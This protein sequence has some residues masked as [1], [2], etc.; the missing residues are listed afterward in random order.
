[1]LAA[2]QLRLLVGACV[3]TCVIADNG[4]DFSNNLFTDLAPLLA[5]FGERVTMQF[6]SQS[7]G[8]A[9]N[10]ILAMAPLGIMTAMVGA[11]RVGGPSWLKAI[12]GRAR[13]SRAVAEAEL[14]SSTSNDVCELWNGQEIVRV[15]GSGPIREFVILLPKGRSKDGNLA[16][17]RGLLGCLT[18]RYPNDGTPSS[19]ERCLEMRAMGLKDSEV[20]GYIEKYELVKN[21]PLAVVRN[22]NAAI[23]NLTLNVHNQVGRGELY[24]VAVLGV[25]LQLG[26]L[27]YCGFATRYLMLPKDG[28]PVDDYA[29]PCTACGTLLLI[30][31]MLLCAHI[32]ETSTLETRYRPGP[33]KEARVIWLQRSGTVNDQAFES[34]AIFPEDRQALVTTSHRASGEQE[35]S[36]GTNIQETITVAGVLIS[37]SGFI[38]Q[39]TGLH[40]MHWSASVAQLGAIIVMTILRAPKAFP[41]ISGHELDWLAMTL[42]KPARAPW[43]LSPKTCTGWKK[44][45]RPWID[46]DDDWDWKVAV[47]EDPKGREILKTNS[48]IDSRSKAHK[49]MKIRRDLSEL[50]DWLGPASIEAISLARAIEIV[51]DA[52]FNT[53]TREF[54]WSLTVSGKQLYFV[55]NKEQERGREKDRDQY[56]AVTTDDTWLQAKGTLVK[57]NLQLLDTHTA[58]LYRDLR[59][60]MPDGPVRVIEVKVNDREPRT[61]GSVLQIEDDRVV[62]FT[63]GPTSSSSNDSIHQYR[64]KP[65]GPP[66]PDSSLAVESFSPLATLYTQY[67]FSAFMWAAA[68]KMEKPLE[69]SAD[70]RRSW[71]NTTSADPALQ[72]IALQSTQLSKMAQD[73]QTTGIGSLEEIYLAIIPPLSAMDRLPRPDPV[74]KWAR[75]QA[76]SHEQLGHWKEAADVYMQLFRTAETFPVEADI[77][78]MATALLVEYLRAV[79]D[80][81]ELGKAQLFDERHVQ[82]LEQ[83]KSDLDTKLQ[84]DCDSGILAELMGLHEAQGRSWRCSFVKE[85]E[86]VKDENTKLKFTTLHKAACYGAMGIEQII[87]ST[88]VNERDIF[89]W[90]PLHYAATEPSGTT[91]QKLLTYR[92]DVNAGDIRRR[93]P[94]HYA[95][96]H[97]DDSIVR[98][99]LQAGAEINL[100]DIDG[101]TPIHHA[102]INGRRRVMRSL[103]KAGATIDVVDGLGNTPLL[104]ATYKAHVDLVE[105]LWEYSNATLRNH[106]GRTPLHLAVMAATSEVSRR[107]KIVELLLEKG[108]DK[109]AKD[110][111]GRTPLSLAAIKG[112]K[113]IVRLLLEKNADKNARDGEGRTPL[114]QAAIKGYEPIIK[115]LLEEG[116]DNEDIDSKDDSGQ[117]PLL[118]ADIDSKDD[119]GQTP[120]LYAA[121]SEHEGVV[122]LLLA[123][124]KADIDSKDDCGQTPLL[125]AAKNGHEGV[126][127]LLQRK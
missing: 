32:V 96:W 120:L 94:L 53:L 83:L 81:I 62:G 69:D 21:S 109:E 40:G 68:K 89:D 85:F 17:K 86:P 67:M 13:E 26:V 97:D 28:N 72:P 110:N 111:G 95:C 52:L 59:W 25:A 6:M 108:A 23:P 115:L 75:E 8:W 116:A 99:L 9:D 56:K 20:Y 51:M 11:I 1:M 106:N 47:V 105:E 117:T 27:V 5:L 66:C 33:G 41:L 126:V 24:V 78:A 39:F 87:S 4:D 61:D 98:S 44:Y 77:H 10:I 58:A 15:M 107:E 84:A 34:F 38:I 7:M 36:A 3:V 57:P 121:K 16:K 74:V 101:M 113:P 73:I 64:R 103:I 88:G 92:A 114:Y 125:W 80:A 90:T 124:G 48:D 119:F 50:A 112:Y 102:V 43:L 18:T 118:W 123:T 65:P 2:G 63:S 31:G 70:L 93:T 60:W 122:K 82:E 76:S 45:C 22:T 29:F 100:R 91:L 19:L 46:G 30:A 37:I 127:K 104:L 55:H 71:S 54:T 14:M 42:G 79:T 12:I 49:L 35:R